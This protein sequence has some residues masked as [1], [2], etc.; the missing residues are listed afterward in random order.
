M[1]KWYCC[2][3]CC[4]MGQLEAA[5]LAAMHYLIGACWQIQ[6][7]TRRRQQSKVEHGDQG[8]LGYASEN[9]ADLVAFA[10]L[11]ISSWCSPSRFKTIGLWAEARLSGIQRTWL[12][13][14]YCIFSDLFFLN[15][16]WILHVSSP[17]KA[18]P[19]RNTVW[20]PHTTN[21]IEINKI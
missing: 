5:C 10:V 20:M 12:H 4:Y 18:D 3:M 9:T 15:L 21:K 19:G 1:Q 17:V 14:D 2:I 13:W 16:W 8:L 7:S 6:S 11:I